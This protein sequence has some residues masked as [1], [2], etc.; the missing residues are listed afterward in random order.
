MSIGVFDSG[1]GGLTVL[2]ELLNILPNESYIYIG[3]N[4][5]CPYGDKTK[6]ELYIY[7]KRIIDYFIRCNVKLIVVACNTTSSNVLDRLKSE[8]SIPIIGVIDATVGDF[9]SR[10]ISTTLIIATNATIN[11]NAYED[12]IKSNNPNIIVY[13]KA[14]PLLVPAIENNDS[15]I[16][17]ILNDYLSEYK[18]KINSIILGCTHY[19]LV[20]SNIK[21]ILG[22]IE[23][24]SSSKSIANIVYKYLK[25]NNLFENNNDVKIY[26]TGDIDLFNKNIKNIINY[27]AK[28]IDL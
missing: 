22:N 11:S 15:N 7:A 13:N 26:T 8:Y 3:D 17:N 27:E 16:N 5:N 21:S 25:D 1:I 28:Y 23:I 2:K 6:E 18:S 4:K 19:L 14:T 20:E 9:I 10:G 24:I 12:R